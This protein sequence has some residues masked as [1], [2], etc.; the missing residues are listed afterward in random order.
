[1]L[2]NISGNVTQRSCKQVT[3][4]FLYIRTNFSNIIEIFKSTLHLFITVGMAQEKL[5]YHQLFSAT[6]HFVCVGFSDCSFTKK[7]GLNL[8]R[9]P[10]QLARES[11]TFIVITT[12]IINIT[13]FLQLSTRKNQLRLSQ[14]LFN[15]RNSRI[16][17]LQ[18]ESKN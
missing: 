8:I 12:W 9:E 3:Y 13:K 15:W 10:T 17:Q 2:R 11:A 14:T 6:M 1:M 18:G 7:L 5:F 4:I 16:L